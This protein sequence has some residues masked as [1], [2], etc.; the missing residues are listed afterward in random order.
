MGPKVSLS[1][2][3]EVEYHLKLAAKHDVVVDLLD[4]L[5]QAMSIAIAGIN[6]TPEKGFQVRR[7]RVKIERT[8]ILV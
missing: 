8:A 5:R 4:S 6:Y 1:S 2:L 7:R 3:K